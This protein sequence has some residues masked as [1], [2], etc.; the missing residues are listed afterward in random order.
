[1][2]H[3]PESPGYKSGSTSRAAATAMTDRAGTLRALAL[4]V[5]ED[6][7][8]GLTADECAQKMGQSI[9]AVR[10]RLTEL[11]HMKKICDTGLRR[12]N[13]SGHS[14]RVMGFLQP[15]NTSTATP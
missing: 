14:A 1:M 2:S 10:P 4:Q 9:L 6:H 13:A 7:P 15:Y 12:R 5:L 11:Q 8:D 3:Y